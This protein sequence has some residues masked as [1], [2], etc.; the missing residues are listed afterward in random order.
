MVEDRKSRLGRSGLEEKAR[1]YRIAD[2]ENKRNKPTSEVLRPFIIK[3]IEFNTI[4]VI[5]SIKYNWP[6]N[7]TV[8]NLESDFI[9]S[10]LF[11]D[12]TNLP[13]NLKKYLPL[14]TKVIFNSKIIIGD[15]IITYEDYSQQFQRDLISS[16][17]GMGVDNYFQRFALINLRV[18]MENYH[19]LSEWTKIAL[20]QISLDV[21]SILA[22]GLRLADN[23]RDEKKTRE[24][25]AGFLMKT[26][27]YGKE[28][29][30]YI[31]DNIASHNL[32]N[33]I[34]DLEHEQQ[35]V[36]ILDYLQQ[37][38]DFMS[39]APKMLK[40]V[41]KFDHLEQEYKYGSDWGFLRENSSIQNQRY[42]AVTN[43][44][45]NNIGSIRAIIN[46]SQEGAYL[47]RKSRIIDCGWNS[48][49]T[50]ALMIIAKYLEIESGPLWENCREAGYCYSVSLTANIDA[51]TLTLE[52]S[53]CSDLK[54]TFNAAR[55][56]MNCPTSRIFH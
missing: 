52:L 27:L 20:H 38:I 43:Q 51:G 48:D 34:A 22:G 39:T 32:H 16:N 15:S 33:H 50:A 35:E 44:T 42:D 3:S 6:I 29:Y 23:A 5:S 25:I 1:L 17:V 46:S 54:K 12:T 7:T 47:I 18:V 49:K 31:F 8:Y 4:P 28:S 21:N 56:T 9:E 53:D 55:Q 11:I 19:K 45:W 37:I 40:I 30:N 41:G 13:S 2:E 10:Y 26:L 36:K 24:N 14:W